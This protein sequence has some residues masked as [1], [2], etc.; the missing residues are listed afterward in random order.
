MNKLL[1]VFNICGISGNENT[2]YYIDSLRSL[3]SQTVASHWGQHYKIVISGCKTSERTKWVLQNSFKDWL[4]YNWIDEEYPLSI[5]FNHT[6][7]QCVERFGEFEGYLYVDSGIS[8]WDPCGRYD[9]LERLWA[10]HQQAPYAITAAFPSN[11]DGSQWWDIQ[12]Q[13]GVD[14]VFPVGKATNMHCQIFSN[15]WRRAYKHILP[16]IFASH[17]MESV[18]SHMCA[19]IHKKYVITQK[20]HLLHNH[21]MDGAS[22]SSRELKKDRYK[23]SEMFETG[24]LLFRTQKT[25]DERYREGR[26]WGAGF[27]ECKPYW[28]HDPNKFDSNGYAI[29]PAELKD[30]YAREFFLK[31]TEFDYSSEIKR[32]FF[33]GK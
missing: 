17:C 22:I 1:A 2:P 21:S 12:Y 24:G 28:P 27:E 31:P 11:D 29:H 4:S 33:P 30:F 8:F 32:M 3:L 18:F 6:V 25:M 19:A 5:T 13:Q 15:D 23:M 9:A 7:D 10:V 16:D 20:V 14:Y 26:Q